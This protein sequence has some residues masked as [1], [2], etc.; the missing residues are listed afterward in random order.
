MAWTTSDRV[1]TLRERS[2][3]FDVFAEMMDGWRRHLSGRNASVLAFFSFLSIFPLMLAAVTILGFV[4]DDDPELRDRIL[5]SAASQIPVLGND[6][7]ENPD[8]IDGSIWAL[9]IGLGAAL[10]SSTKA[11]VGLQGALDDTWE[12]DVDDRAGL[13]AQRGRAL[14]GLAVVGSALIASIVIASIVNKAGFPAISNVALVFATVVINILVI[15]TM[16][17]FLTSATPSWGDVWPG[18][19]IAGV[20]FTVLQTFGTRLVT[21]FAGASEASNQSMQVIGVVIG[22]ITWM[23][24]V[25]ITVIMCAELN[26]ARKRI[27]DGPRLEGANLDIAIRT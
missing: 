17:R 13:P 8:S 7:R 15:A 12:I 14:L 18:A 1:M 6:L 4:L 24:L 9:V 21:R 22:L 27:Q 20:I 16:Y 5:D 19:I 3:A 23:S 10:W 25:G 26:A 11:F 2:H